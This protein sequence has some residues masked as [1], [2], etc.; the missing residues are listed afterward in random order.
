MASNN[1]QE[2]QDGRRCLGIHLQ[3]EPAAL[4]QMVAFGPSRAQLIFPMDLIL[5]YAIYRGQKTL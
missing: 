1:E 2:E 5:V 3:P 4:E